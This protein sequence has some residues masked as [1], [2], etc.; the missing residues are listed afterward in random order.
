MSI[1][2]PVYN[3]METVHRCLHSVVNQSFGDFEVI[4]VDDG[5][6]D[7]TGDIVRAF[8]EKDE[9]IRYII[10]RNAGVSSARNVG[11]EA[12]I[13]TY[14]LFIDA[15]DIIED[16]YLDSIATQA[17]LTDAD[18]LIWGIK[19]CFAD[20]RID[21]WI[22]ETEGLFDRKEFLTVFPSEQYGQHKGLYGFVANKLVKK[23]IVDRFFLH[24][25]T[26]MSLQEDYSFF[27]DC[28]SHCNRF[29]CFRESGY[30][31]NEVCPNTPPKRREI[32]YPKLI[33]TQIKC[34]NLLDKEGAFDEKNRRLV[35]NAIANLSFS[36]F[37]EMQKADFGKVRSCMVFLWE[38]PLCI[39]AVRD[40]DTRW[41]ALKLWILSRNVPGVYIFTKLWR[42]YLYF[43]KGERS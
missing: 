14:L 27:L 17:R 11:I 6:T 16:G 29:L 40:K 38:N 19:R 1:V 18:I 10:K 12:A 30:R 31:Y 5:S 26:T 15:D 28:F 25:D 42:A 24:F 35:S 7:G 39:S 36:M 33:E 23:A 22:P 4:V 34:A 9:R 41:K 13:G 43:R 3:M 8:E 20:G 37:L 32:S 21:K 2:I